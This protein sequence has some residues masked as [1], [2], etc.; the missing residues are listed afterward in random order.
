ML[1]GLSRFRPKLRLRLMLKILDRFRQKRR[2]ES[3]LKILD[4]FQQIRKLENML[5]ILDQ[6][7]HR[8]KVLKILNVLDQFQKIWKLLK[9]M[10]QYPHKLRKLKNIG[11]RIETSWLRFLR[12]GRKV[13]LKEE[14]NQSNNPN[15]KSTW[16]I[17]NETQTRHRTLMM[18]I[19]INNY[20]TLIKMKN[21]F[22]N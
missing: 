13:E 16:K 21:N 11:K 20:L 9:T 8:V 12:M 6:F 15:T 1:E 22:K 18:K 14:T 17:S 7:H 2:Q 4:R 3:M 19:M 5:D 10:T